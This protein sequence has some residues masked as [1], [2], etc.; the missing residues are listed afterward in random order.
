MM[1]TEH[2]GEGLLGD[3]PDKLSDLVRWAVSDARGL[4]RDKYEPD[5]AVWHSQDNRGL[6]RVCL[7][8]VVLVGTFKM[9]RTKNARMMLNGVGLND[10]WVRKLFTLELIRADNHAQL[11][12]WLGY[13]SRLNLN[14]LPALTHTNFIG[15]FEFDQFL[16]SL[17]RYAEALEVQGC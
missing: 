5:A 17:E 10:R 8:G 14:I 2:V 1:I 9:P 11:Q 6:C 16:T 3:P 7:A 12:E 4:D 15:W 13:G